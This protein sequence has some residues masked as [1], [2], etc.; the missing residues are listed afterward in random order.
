MELLA[1]KSLQQQWLSPASAPRRS[2]GPQRC[3]RRPRSRRPGIGCLLGEFAAHIPV[4][5]TA[6]SLTKRLA[7]SVKSSTPGSGV[8]QEFYYNLSRRMT[9]RDD[10][11]TGGV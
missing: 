4:G 9:D 1:H 3:A 6:G 7:E 10:I 8:E 11:N 2:T 5:F